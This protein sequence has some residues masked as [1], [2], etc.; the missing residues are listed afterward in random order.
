MKWLQK[1]LCWLGPALLMIALLSVLLWR[2]GLSPSQWVPELNSWIILLLSVSYFI[3]SAVRIYPTHVGGMLYAYIIG[4]TAGLLLWQTDISINKYLLGHKASVELPGLHYVKLITAILYSLLVAVQCIL[5]K[6]NSI[7]SDQLKRQSEISLL[8]REA[9]LYKLRQQLQP[10]FLYNSLNSINALIGIQP[11][12][13]QEMVV[14]LSDFLRMAVK[15]DNEEKVSLEQELEYIQAYLSIEAI[16]FGDRLNVQISREPDLGGTM[17]PF[18][19]QPLLENAVKYGIYGTTGAI[20]I[21]LVIARNEEL[22][23][24]TIINPFD[25][26][27]NVR[28][29]TG[30]GLDGVRQRLQLLF[31]RSDLLDT[32]RSEGN[33]I[34]T[35]KIPQS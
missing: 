22:M 11:E 9:A 8:H 12:K 32:V 1:H 14:K 31:G 21:S 18:L 28:S 26:S 5:L 15:R 13:A 10:H 27:Q 23:I 35:L 24:I 20:T 7:I 2:S 34:T 29:G 6:K 4:L 25:A 19:L 17:P 30:F 3:Y 33:F 16:R